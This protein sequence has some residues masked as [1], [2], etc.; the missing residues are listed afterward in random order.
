MKKNKSVPIEVTKAI[1]G[2]LKKGA[3]AGIKEIW[4]VVI[5]M[6]AG[7]AVFLFNLSGKRLN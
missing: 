1:L 6:L 3:L 5:G 2:D 7:I 4:S